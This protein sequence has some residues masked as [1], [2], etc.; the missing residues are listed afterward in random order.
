MQLPLRS[1]TPGCR[2]P[3]YNELDGRRDRYL[4]KLSF[5][6]KTAPAALARPVVLRDPIAVRHR[7]ARR[8][9][10]SRPWRSAAVG[11][12]CGG[13]VPVQAV[14]GRAA[15]REPDLLQRVLD[16][17]RRVSEGQERLK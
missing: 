12:G 5:S 3:R 10:L 8:A 7:R 2:Y 9:L 16:A 4:P 13:R 17:G 6:A 15:V 14:A 11:G 1:G